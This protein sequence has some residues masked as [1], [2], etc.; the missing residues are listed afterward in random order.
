LT[1]KEV[2]WQNK[3]NRYFNFSGIDCRNCGVWVKFFKS[4][5]VTPIAVKNETYIVGLYW[6]E[7][8]EFAVRSVKIGDI[9]RD[10]DRGAILEK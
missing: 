8:P 9:A 4:G 6:E 10:F 5:S 1:V 7:S 2:V 3:Y